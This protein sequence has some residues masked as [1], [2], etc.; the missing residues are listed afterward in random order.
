MSEMIPINNDEMVQEIEGKYPE[1]CEMLR[2]FLSEEYDLFIRKQNDY[3]TS[4]VTVG[5]DLNDPDGRKV[6]MSALI[7]RINDKVQRLLNL[8]VKKGAIQAA[9]EPIEDAF[10]DISLLSKMARIVEKGK[11]GK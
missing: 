10:K 11:W 5:Q 3:G 8:V 9:N 6:A 7:F 4:N 2:D 1:T